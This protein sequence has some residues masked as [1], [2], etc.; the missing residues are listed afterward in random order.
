MS[1]SHQTPRDIQGPDGSAARPMPGGF[2][3]HD[4]RKDGPEAVISRTLLRVCEQ[5]TTTLDVW[6][7][8]SPVAQRCFRCTGTLS[9][10]CG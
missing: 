2:A 8:S 7:C 6:E 10:L 1:D 9:T 3:L 5:L 4:D